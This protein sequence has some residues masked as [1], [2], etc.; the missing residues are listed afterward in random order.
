MRKLLMYTL[1]VIIA[2]ATQAQSKKTK[3][4]L[5]YSNKFTLGT[6][7]AQLFLLGGFNSNVT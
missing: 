4:K 1:L 5:R 7:L 2:F 3:K 6:D